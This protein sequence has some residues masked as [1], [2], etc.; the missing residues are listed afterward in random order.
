V[1]NGFS[2]AFENV[3]RKVPVN[4]LNAAC[5]ALRGCPPTASAGFVPSRGMLEPGGDNFTSGATAREFLSPLAREGRCLPVALPKTVCH[6]AIALRYCWPNSPRARPRYPRCAKRHSHRRAWPATA[7]DR[8]EAPSGRLV[9][10]SAVREIRRRGMAGRG[11]PAYNDEECLLNRRRPAVHVQDGPSRR[12]QMAC[13]FRP[14]YRMRA[15]FCTSGSICPSRARG[16]KGSFA[17]KRRLVTAHVETRPLAFP[18]FVSGLRISV[19]PSW[20]SAG[21]VPIDE[22]H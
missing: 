8:L 21:S 4:W 22:K 2:S 16:D 1:A 13:R 12:E 18:L 19:R 17:E 5:K 10:M 9:Q 3:I 7:C 15:P 11:A 14:L 6:L 20:R